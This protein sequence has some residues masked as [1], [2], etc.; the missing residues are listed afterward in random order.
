M[1]KT[2]SILIALT[3]CL[4]LML[5]MVASAETDVEKAIKEAQ[6]MTWDEL[7]AKAKEEIGDGELGIMSTTSRVINE[8]SFTK[9]T[10]IKLAE[11]SNPNDS[12]IYELMEGEIGAGLYTADVILTQDSFMLVNKAVANG[13]V[14]NYVPKGL[15]DI[16]L[17][18]DLN[19]L[20]CTYNTRLF[21]YNDGGNKEMKL[22]TNVWQLTEPEF[23]GMEFKNPV[24]EKTSMNCLIT[25]TSEKYQAKLAEA[26][27]E[28]Y[29]KEWVS[30]GTYMNI[31][32]EWIHK[33]IMN[34]TFINKDS[35]IAK[36][37]ADGAPGSSGLFVFSKLRS[38][39][40]TNIT[41]SCYDDIQG[42]AGFLYPIYIQIAA[43]AKYPYTACLFVN[44]CTSVEG[45]TNVWGKDMGSYSVNPEAPISENAKSFGDQPL[46]Y[47]QDCAI[48][49]DPVHL[50]NVY[51]F[52]YTQIAMWCASK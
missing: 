13:W 45:Y 34:C 31:A 42:F 9:L 38:V 52:A 1:K 2:L 7:L 49:E 46:A 6:N 19:P 43:N 14:L 23:A 35:T 10:G 16:A 50:Q 22:Y 25:M 48:V 12:K 47:W 27:K 26:Y 15:A 24:D 3:L 5:P 29:G 37:I 8:E 18:S 17:E 39:D 30:D 28:Y 4:G 20:V 33:F 44:Y 40:P 32:Y 11:G 21:F 51:A 41:C 36:D